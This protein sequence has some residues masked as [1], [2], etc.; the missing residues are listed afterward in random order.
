MKEVEHVASDGDASIANNLT[1][2]PIK[3]VNQDYEDDI[4]MAKMSDMHIEKT[5][6][7]NKEN[8]KFECGLCSYSAARKD[9]L[10]KHREAVHE[11]I[12]KYK[13]GECTYSA[14]Q[15]FHLRRHKE[16]V[17]AKTINYECA[18]CILVNLY[19]FDAIYILQ[20]MEDP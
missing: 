17:H 20:C 8:K 16:A 5:S 4:E 3:N 12:K 15:K 14:A 18:I 11:K 7:I 2:L 10:K 6:A 9:H 1:Y 13:C 19:N